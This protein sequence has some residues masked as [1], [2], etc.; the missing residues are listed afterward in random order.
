MSFF[1]VGQQVFYF[2]SRSQ[3]C[4]DITNIQATLELFFN[5]EISVRDVSSRC[6]LAQA[7][8]ID[9][10]KLAPGCQFCAH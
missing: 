1:G 7:L 5:I 3:A 4:V 8:F 2:S 6:G 9:E 10:C